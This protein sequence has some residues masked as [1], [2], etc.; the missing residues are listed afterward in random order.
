MDL[1]VAAVPFYFGSM[2]AER[3]WLRARSDDPRFDTGQYD[4]PDTTANLIMGTASLVAPIATMALRRR[5]EL[6]RGRW[7]K[8]LLAIGLAGVAATTVADQILRRTAPDDT[9]DDH[10]GDNSRRERRR[11]VRSLATK[12]A[13]VGS[14]TAVV[15]IGLVTTSTWGAKLSTSRLWERRRMDLG[16]GWKPL[17]AAIV[18][19]DFIYYWNHRSWH[20]SRF[21][22]AIHVVH[23]SSERYN[24]SVALRQPVAD[25]LGVFVPY[26]LLCL[27]GV[28]PALVESA[29]G[30]NLIYQYWIHTEA[31]PKLGPLE[32]P[33]NTASHHRVHHG[34]NAQYIDRNHGSIL[35]LWDRLF[36]TFEAEGEQVVYGLTSNLNT[37]SP[38]AIAGHEHVEMLADVARS[39][40]WRERLSYV[41]RGPGWAYEQRRRRGERPPLVAEAI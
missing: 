27:V 7:A 34:T 23:H 38:V 25:A 2:E 41:F 13:E 10:S 15:A 39:T 16:T 35:I 3:R 18:G 8:P 30:I 6:G 40:S 11:R 26:G 14:V 4:R 24:L 20:E 36:G 28:S 9:T 17:L 1:T 21:L 5:L 29:R 33:L 31:I 32:A 22:W 12:T 37:F 19:W